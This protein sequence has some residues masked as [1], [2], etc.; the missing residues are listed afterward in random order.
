VYETLRRLGYLY[1]SE[2][3]ITHLCAAGCVIVR[4]CSVMIAVRCGNFEKMGD[5]AGTIEK[6]FYLV[7][8]NIG[9]AHVLKLEHYMIYSSAMPTFLNCLRILQ[10]YVRHYLP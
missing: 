9:M 5:F 8:G 7:D 2:E 10:Q 6:F 1:L 3:R 4:E